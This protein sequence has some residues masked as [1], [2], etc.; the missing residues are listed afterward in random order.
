MLKNQLFKRRL[1]AGFLILLGMMT[2]AYAGG[3]IEPSEDI[4]EDSSEEQPVAVQPVV[5]PTV[6]FEPASYEASWM[7]GRIRIVASTVVH[8]DS[9]SSLPESMSIAPLPFGNLV[10]ESA[11]LDGAEAD[12]MVRDGHVLVRVP[13]GRHLLKVTGAL[14]VSRTLGGRHAEWNPGLPGSVSVPPELRIDGAV[15]SGL[16]YLLSGSPVKVIVGSRAGGT[17]AGSWNVS[18]QDTFDVSVGLLTSDAVIEY[19]AFGMAPETFAV[20]YPVNLNVISIDG[21][22]QALE[23]GEGRAILLPVSDAG[24][25]RIRAEGA[26]ARDRLTLDGLDIEGAGR[27]EIVFG[28]I[29][30]AELYLDPREQTGLVSDPAGYRVA[31]WPYRYEAALTGADVAE[32]RGPSIGSAD[33]TVSVLDDGRCFG[34]VS[35]YLEE[36]LAQVRLFLPEGAELLS[37]V[38]GDKAVAPVRADSGVVIPTLNAEVATVVYRLKAGVASIGSYDLPLPRIEPTVRS[39]SLDLWT[40]SGTV[41]FRADGAWMERDGRMSVLEM[42]DESGH[43]IGQAWALILKVAFWIILCGAV[44]WLLIF[45]ARQRKLALAMALAATGILIVVFAMMFMPLFDM[46]S[47]VGKETMGHNQAA[48]SGGIYG[49]DDAP[50]EIADKVAAIPLASSSRRSGGYSILMEIPTE[51]VQQTFE[52]IE[53]FETGPLHL[54]VAHRALWSVLIILVV[55]FCG[56]LLFRRPGRIPIVAVTFAFADSVIPGAFIASWGGMAAAAVALIVRRLRSS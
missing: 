34:E 29:P 12:L 42:L 25:I 40:P 48:L 32:G 19:E 26:I 37:A 21:D 3:F 49:G 2:V 6:A 10:I 20:R 51:G 27:K 53:P 38:A 13:V 4:P 46:G 55:A 54:T 44:V 43:F 15:S 33:Y 7:D 14:G 52:S 22:A 24:R 35:V 41:I 45:I 8:A 23:V 47:H 1:L 30:A 16:E 50:A 39:S 36:P 11:R 28:V 9:S 56:F 5:S 18:L 31:S 17:G